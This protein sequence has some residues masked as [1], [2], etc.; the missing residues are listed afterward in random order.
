MAK[1]EVW[2]FL[3]HETGQLV[4]QT[5][6]DAVELSSSSSISR[7]RDAVR[8]KNP[9]KLSHCDPSSLVVYANNEAFERKDKLDPRIKIG[10]ELGKTM[11]SLWLC[12]GILFL[13]RVNAKG[14]NQ[15]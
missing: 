10:K 12:L 11:S 13:L 8:A 7:F 4:E 9:T 15:F 6:T 3:V 1:R 2:Y 5:S 14:W